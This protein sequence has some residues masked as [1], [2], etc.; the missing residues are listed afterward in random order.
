MERNK[1]PKEQ[2][3]QTLKLYAK[4][5]KAELP[6]QASNP[7]IQALAASINRTISSVVMRLQNFEYYA[8]GGATGLKNGS[9]MCAIV[10]DEMYEALGLD[11]P[12][13]QLPATSESSVNNALSPALSQTASK[14]NEIVLNIAL[15][16]NDISMIKSDDVNLFDSLIT[17][18]KY[19]D[20]ESFAMKDLCTLSS[21]V[22]SI[23][24]YPDDLLRTTLKSSLSENEYNKYM[25]LIN[26]FK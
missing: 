17:L 3:V 1:W 11:A 22:K 8:T 5:K 12:K 7:E 15:K 26:I 2:Y 14:I 25:N 24:D 21:A 19:L 4:L 18:S 20:S 9:K 10:F 6:M 13:S 16:V 23:P